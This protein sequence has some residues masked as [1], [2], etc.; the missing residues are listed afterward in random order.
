[1]I[2]INET[3]SSIHNG[4]DTFYEFIS[5]AFDRIDTVDLT[6]P[7][8]WALASSIDYRLKYLATR[9][10]AGERESTASSPSTRCR[11]CP[12]SNSEGSNSPPTGSS[13]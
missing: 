8:F 9:G 2:T 1:M 7:E 5:S 3:V 6:D 10:E 12:P 4:D 13:S 11:G